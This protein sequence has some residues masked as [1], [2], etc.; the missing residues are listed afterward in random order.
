M[1][2]VINHPSYDSF[3]KSRNLLPHLK[4]IKHAVMTVGGWYDA[5]D[6]AGP[7]N[8]YKTIEKTIQKQ[9]TLLLW[10]RFLMVDGRE[11]LENIIIMIFILVTVL[12]RFTK[13]YGIQIL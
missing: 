1:Q 4:G 3:W 9:K 11:K 2:E 8:I 7:L 6:L 13:K 10:A 12:L 5:E